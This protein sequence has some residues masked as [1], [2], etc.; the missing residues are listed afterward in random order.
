MAGGPPH[1]TR[2]SPTD[3]NKDKPWQALLLMAAF[4][5]VTGWIN[6]AVT[7]VA[8]AVFVPYIAKNNPKVD[9]RLLVTAA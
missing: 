5:F 2:V 4:A 9:Y 6:W 7:I 1:I 3:P 8:S